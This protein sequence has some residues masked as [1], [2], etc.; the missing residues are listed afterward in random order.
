MK[1]FLVGL[2]ISL[3]GLVLVLPARTHAQDS[4]AS[5]QV[6][7]EQ[8]PG[9]STTESETITKKIGPGG[10]VIEGKERTK[11]TVNLHGDYKYSGVPCKWQRK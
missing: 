3:A 8:K 11:K 9:T 1:T 4:S 5:V 2:I 7:P 6:G 10:D